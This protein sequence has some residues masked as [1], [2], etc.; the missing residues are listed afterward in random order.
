[1]SFASGPVS[2]QRFHIDGHLPTDVTDRFVAALNKH[3][4]G[5]SPPRPDGTQSGWVGPS[6]VLDTELRAEA[7]ACGGYVHLALRVDQLKP[8]PSILRAYARLEEDALR[9]SSGRAFLNRAEQRQAKEKARLR[10]EQEARGGQFRR[11]V[12]YPVLIDLEHQTVYFAALSAPAADRLMQLFY[13]TFGRGL[14][15][16][17]PEQAAGRVLERS[18]DARKLESLT[19]FV[20]VPPPGAAH[21]AATQNTAGDASFL[22]KEFLTWLWYHTDADEGPLKVR[23]G[24]EITVMIDKVLRMKCDFGLTGTTAITADG[25]ANLPEARAALGSGKQPASMGLVLGSPLGE[26]RLTLDGPRL[27]VA[28]LVLPEDDSED[29]PRARL[30]RRFELT[31]DAA[32]LLDALF[33]VFVLLRTGRNWPRELRSLSAWATRLAGAALHVVSA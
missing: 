18:G 28:G 8:P 6:H 31:A 7:V 22:G 10:A 30:E 2:F 13:D 1:M 33:E 9:Q 5:H 15:P 4:F 32:H 14:T 27:A 25:P 26:M 29:D 23:S 19:P 20:L 11:I 17:N 21:E 3:A 24:D 12:A 16:V